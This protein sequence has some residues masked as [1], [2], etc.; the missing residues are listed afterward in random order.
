[1]ARSSKSMIG[2]SQAKRKA[3]IK[4]TILLALHAWKVYIGGREEGRVISFWSTIIIGTL[5]KM[6][7]TTPMY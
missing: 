4:T 6:S 1:M 7:V 5:V 2:F 3:S